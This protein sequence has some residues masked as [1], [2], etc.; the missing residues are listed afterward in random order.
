MEGYR[1]GLSYCNEASEKDFIAIDQ[2]KIHRVF[3]NIMR[4]AIE[5]VEPPLK[6]HM[7]FTADKKY[8]HFCMGDNG[9][10]IPENEL[11]QIFQSFYRIDKSRSRDK[12]GSGLGLAICKSII[13]AHG[14]QIQAYNSVS[15]GLGIKFSLPKVKR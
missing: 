8:V 7:S 5:Y 4:N 1:A 9:P 10:G 12:G 2:K 13:E 3:A 6:V 11:S 15:G 14:G